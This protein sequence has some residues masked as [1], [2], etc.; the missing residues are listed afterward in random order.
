MKR[1]AQND[2]QREHRVQHNEP[3]VVLVVALADAVAEPW[4][5]VVEAFHTVVAHR[6]MPSK[7]SNFNALLKK[8]KPTRLEAVSECCRFGIS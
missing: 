4:A 7:I 5:M 2:V 3:Q 1:N 8:R 6:A